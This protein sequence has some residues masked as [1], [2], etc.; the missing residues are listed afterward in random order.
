MRLVRF[1]HQTDTILGITMWLSLGLVYTAFYL[2]YL[3]FRT[4]FFANIAI[5]AT[6][7]LIM[8]LRRT[9]PFWPRKLLN[10]WTHYVVL[11][12][13]LALGTL[14]RSYEFGTFPPPD[15]QHIEEAQT[16]GLAFSSLTSKTIY[17]YFP[18][19]DLLAQ[20]G[21]VS[22]GHTMTAIRIPFLIFGI[23]SVVFFFIASRLLLKSF[24]AAAIASILFACSA[25]LAGSSRIA[26]ETMSPVATLTIALAGAFYAVSRRDHASMVFAGFATGLLILEYFSFKPIAV[27][28]I[29]FVSLALMQTRAE[30]FCEESGTR[31]QFSALREH[32]SHIVLL[33]LSFFAVAFPILCF[34]KTRP[35]SLLFE[36]LWRHSQSMEAISKSV[37]LSDLIWSQI[38]NVNETW[39]FVFIGG[40]A[41][42]DILPENMGLIEFSTG[43]AGVIALVYCLKSVWQRPTRLLLVGTILLTVILGGVLV[44]NP[45]RYRLIPIIPFYYLIIGVALDDMFERV[46]KRKSLMIWRTVLIIIIAVGLNGYHFFATAMHHRQVLDTFVDLNV[47][48]SLMIADIQNEHPGTRVLL[49]SNRKFLE[50]FN[51]YYFL[52]DKERLSVSETIPA[53]TGIP[54][55]ALAHDQFVEIL[56]NYSSKSNCEEWKTIRNR[57]MK[58]NLP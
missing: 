41:Q 18:L 5:L 1:P 28:L 52:Y 57:F 51:D 30:P 54:T 7:C 42:N 39:R 20:I 58:C 46:R 14:F 3:T 4:V 37:S 36:G 45:S 47:E 13:I 21:L 32:R 12:I 44:T 34:D 2:D 40:T 19:T 23:I 29:G 53:L 38:K 17:P 11:L 56:A 9:G 43:V 8:A 48:V 6:M 22:F 26:L 50:N 15:G 49:I 25:Y 10:H 35:F 24:Y 33:I 27:Y 31:Y 16:G 55:I